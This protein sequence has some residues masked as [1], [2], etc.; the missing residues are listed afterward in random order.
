MN[1]LPSRQRAISS[2]CWANRA[3][4]PISLIGVPIQAGREQ[5]GRDSGPAH[6]RFAIASLAL[7]MAC[8]LDCLAMVPQHSD[9]APTRAAS[10]AQ[11]RYC[12]DPDVATE[13]VGQGMLLVHLGRGTTFRLN[14]TGRLVWD[15]IK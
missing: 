14:H 12:Q 2:A 9:S 15:L 10:D 7:G 3:Q 6:C 8:P 5:S 4:P 1:R 13:S 11:A